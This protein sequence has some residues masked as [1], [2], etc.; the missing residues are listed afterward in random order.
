MCTHKSNHC[1]T[2]FAFRLAC[3]CLCVFYCPSAVIE[4]YAEDINP[5]CQRFLKVQTNPD[6]CSQAHVFLNLFDLLQSA[7]HGHERMLSTHAP[8]CGHGLM[9]Q[10]PRPDFDVT[11]TPCQDFSPAGQHR[12]PWGPQMAIFL[13]WVHIVLA[14]AIPVVLH[15]NVPQFWVSLL[16]QF[17]GHAYFVIHCHGLW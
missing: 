13:A 2:Y 12:G 10:V 4:N 8:C 11:G 15:E 3:H 17:M 5:G 6:G 1:F 16:E 7:S 14:I 9:C